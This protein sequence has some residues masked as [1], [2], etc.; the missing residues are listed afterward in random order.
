MGEEP[1]RLMHAKLIKTTVI[2]RYAGLD[3]VVDFMTYPRE[4]LAEIE[5]T[6]MSM[7]QEQIRRVLDVTRALALMV[8]DLAKG[9]DEKE[10]NEKYVNILKIDEDCKEIKR[11][12]EEQIMKAGSLLP[13]REDYMR[14]INNI[15]KIS[16]KAEAA[17]Y[18]VLSLNKTGVSGNT[19]CSYICDL[20][21][22]V[23]SIIS[24]LREA[25]FASRLS[26]VTF[27]QKL[28][29]IEQEERRIDEVYRRVDLQIL[30]SKL[31]IPHMLLSREVVQLL[32]GIADKAEET[33][34]M[35]RALFV[36]LP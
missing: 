15:D 34:D 36:S 26:A 8:D 28:G 19:V 18:R 3:G 6:I 16:D 25:I 7:A 10:M 5:Y 30:Q 23:L 29:E 11:S 27:Y 33:A 32:E 2:T 17:A 24:K 9:K 4:R 1:D 21:D 31:S 35:L 14:L 12:I 22:S 20:S 13:E